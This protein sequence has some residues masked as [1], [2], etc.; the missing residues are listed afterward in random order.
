MTLAALAAQSPSEAAALSR[1]LADVRALA[2][3]LAE[4]DRLNLLVAGRAMACVQAYL[5][6]LQP[7][8]SAYDRRGAR[9]AA[10]RS[11]TT[12][13]KVVGTSMADLFRVLSAGAA[14][15]A[16]QTAAAATAANNLENVNTPRLR[17]PAR[18]PL[19][20]GAGAS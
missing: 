18:D 2:S 7:V 1:A 10:S 3:A 17:A 20:R 9:T 15:L 8:P 13:S 19:R 11:G 16:A 14:S 6:A 5:N 12:W 4:L